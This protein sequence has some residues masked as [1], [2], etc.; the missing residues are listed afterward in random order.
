MPALHDINDLNEQPFHAKQTPEKQVQVLK[1]RVRDAKAQVGWLQAHHAKEIRAL[2][3]TSDRHDREQLQLKAE[4]TALR[5]QTS[6]LQADNAQSRDESDRL[7][8]QLQRR[9]QEPER[10][11]KLEIQ[12]RHTMLQI[13]M[14]RPLSLM[15]AAVHSE[16]T[17]EDL[18]ERVRVRWAGIEQSHARMRQMHRKKLLA[19]RQDIHMEQQRFHELSQALDQKGAEVSQASCGH[20]GRRAVA[21]TGCKRLLCGECYDE[22]R[23]E[24]R[25]QWVIPRCSYCGMACP[26]L[27]VLEE[28]ME[29][30]GE[31]KRASL[32]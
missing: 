23:Q 13:D 3:V 32:K 10:L 27:P 5:S 21:V 29:A 6:R 11:R 12:V 4:L 19:M 28:L 8:A 22:A 9:D 1:Q 2:S 25:S 16:V 30:H 14:R 18:L 31:G 20:E 17:S 24:L 26:L 15:E 7:Q